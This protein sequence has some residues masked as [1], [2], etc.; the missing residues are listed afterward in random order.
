MTKTPRY[1]NRTQ[2]MRCKA[3]ITL[4]DGSAADCQRYRAKGSSYC[5]QHTRMELA[6]SYTD[7]PA[8][9][10]GDPRC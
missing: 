8:H 2:P 9:G 1:L 5:I 7:T 3:V 4:R 10:W 6:R